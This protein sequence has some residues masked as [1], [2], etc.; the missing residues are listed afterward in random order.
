[1]ITTEFMVF[2]SLLNRKKVIGF[3]THEKFHKITVNAICELPVVKEKTASCCV[4]CF[5]LFD[6]FL[7]WHNVNMMFRMTGMLVV[8]AVRHAKWDGACT[9]HGHRP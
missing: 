3:I 4:S 9:T 5:K 2:F 7:F 1:M 8:V 6:S